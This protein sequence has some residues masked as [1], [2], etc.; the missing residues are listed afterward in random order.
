MSLERARE[1]FSLSTQ[2]HRE[3]VSLPRDALV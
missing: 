3:E 2:T 1:P